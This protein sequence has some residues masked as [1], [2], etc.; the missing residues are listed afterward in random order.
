MREIDRAWASFMRFGPPW[1][2]DNRSSAHKIHPES[3]LNDC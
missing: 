3:D 2:W 1:K